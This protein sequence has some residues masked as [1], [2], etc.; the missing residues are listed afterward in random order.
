MDCK[1][2][3][4][5][6]PSVP[7]RPSDRIA[8]CEIS[9]V[10]VAVENPVRKWDSKHTQ[11]P[12]YLD[13]F[14][15]LTAVTIYAWTRSFE[16]TTSRCDNYHTDHREQTWPSSK[17]TRCTQ[18]PDSSTEGTS[19]QSP[20]SWKP[21]KDERSNPSEPRLE[22][23]RPST[24]QM[25]SSSWHS[26]FCSALHI[27]KEPHI[28]SLPES[29]TH[30]VRSSTNSA[31][32]HFPSSKNRYTTAVLQNKSLNHQHHFNPPSMPSKIDPTGPT[33]P[34]IL[35][36]P[37]CVIKTHPLPTLLKPSRTTSSGSSSSRP[38]P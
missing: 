2:T 26:K 7:T 33:A 28:P 29:D 32:W 18:P 24:L 17:P 11:T 3:N 5:H 14:W 34:H 22:F 8:C 1:S 16:A 13:C 30:Y 15:T 37:L 6:W 36:H 12:L 10:A 9:N 23:S 38:I 27:G 20:S 25:R 19:T 21:A 31:G 35:S 4:R